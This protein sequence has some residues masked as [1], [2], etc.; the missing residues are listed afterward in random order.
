MFLFFRNLSISGDN[1]DHCVSD[2][3][4]WIVMS[5][6]FQ[7]VKLFKWRSEICGIYICFLE[8]KDFHTMFFKTIIISET[9]ILSV[10]L[11]LDNTNT[12]NG[13]L[14][15]HPSNWRLVVLC[16]IMAVSVVTHM[17]YRI[18]NIAHSSEMQG[19]LTVAGSKQI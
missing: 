1:N 19:S 15:Q 7:N 16:V 9:L 13:K 4:R 10:F 12:A 2:D 5:Y 11:I 18:M 14:L 3:R 17:F 6:L 8:H